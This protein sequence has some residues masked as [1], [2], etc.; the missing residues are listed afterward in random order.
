MTARDLGAKCASCS[1][2]S[3]L[4]LGV[5]PSSSSV[6]SE[7]FLFSLCASV[8]VIRFDLYLFEYNWDLI[9]K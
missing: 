4:V 5:I 1:E 9:N 7:L 8:F 6:T 3:E 2:L